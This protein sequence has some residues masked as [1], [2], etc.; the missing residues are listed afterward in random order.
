MQDRRGRLVPPPEGIAAEFVV[1]E[2]GKVRDV[3]MYGRPGSFSDA[4]K[5][6]LESCQYRPTMKDG[7]PVPDRVTITITPAR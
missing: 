5:R 2:Q 7:Q 4:Y 6:Y 1:D 3:Q